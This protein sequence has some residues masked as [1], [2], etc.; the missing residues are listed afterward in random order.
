MERGLDP[1]GKNDIR[2]QPAAQKKNSAIVSIVVAAPIIGQEQTE[3]RGPI[4]FEHALSIDEVIQ[5]S[6]FIRFITDRLHFVISQ[7]KRK[8]IKVN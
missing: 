3:Q 8:K 2:A 4:Q 5:F 7:K 6:S 1:I